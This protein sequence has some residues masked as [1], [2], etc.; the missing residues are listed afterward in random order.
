M[1][2]ELVFFIYRR[3]AKKSIDFCEEITI[4]RDYDADLSVNPTAVCV[5]FRP[6][7][8]REFSQQ[9]KNELKP[10]CAHH[11]LGYKFSEEG[12]M[13]WYQEKMTNRGSRRRGMT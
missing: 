12:D 9:E 11:N 10:L 13:I 5:K 2:I 7:N 8:K 6:K 3:L 4:C 1:N